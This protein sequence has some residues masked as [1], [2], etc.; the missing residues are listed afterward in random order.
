MGSV[1]DCYDSARCESFNAA[2]ECELLV[3]HRFTNQN[4]ASIAI[5][6]F[7]EGFYNTHRRH[8]AIG[9]IS[10]AEYERRMGQAA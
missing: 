3:R 6:D 7:I 1:G 10:P 8:T 9:L 5:F 2:I 4:E